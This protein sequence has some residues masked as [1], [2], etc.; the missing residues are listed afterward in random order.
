M[1]HRGGF[2][3]QLDTEKMKY[4]SWF[5]LLLFA[6]FFVVVLLFGWFWFCFWLYF[7]FDLSLVL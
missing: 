7:N 4:L 6:C 1:H 5:F 3:S 2:L